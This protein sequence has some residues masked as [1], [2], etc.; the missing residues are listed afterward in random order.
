MSRTAFLSSALVVLLGLSTLAT[1]SKPASPFS[2]MLEQQ[3]DWS[4]NGVNETE[5][6]Y[7]FTMVRG[8]IDGAQKGLYA[9]MNLK[10]K[11]ECMGEQ[12]Y[13]DIIKLE[14]LLSGGDIGGLFKSSGAIFNLAYS[15]DKACDF[16]ELS[17]QL[18]QFAIN[19]GVTL[20]IVMANL[21]K[22]IFTLIGN[23]N[24]I[25]EVFFGSDN[26]KIEWTN[27]DGCF[28]KYQTLGTQVGKIFRAI[29]NFTG[30]YPTD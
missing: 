12:A 20:E 3:Q 17:Y 19:S 30:S 29:F 15:F 7:Y 16:N 8:Y 4:P 13:K 10:L 28:T 22:N 25:L 1:A 23:I 5:F 2:A 18:T 14:A 6:R 26:S 9:D 24:E 27:L 21:Q 11:Q